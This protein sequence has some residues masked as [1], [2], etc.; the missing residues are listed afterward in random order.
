MARIALHSRNT[1]QKKCLLSLKG[2]VFEKC[3]LR[4]I[5]RILVVL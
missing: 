4:V 5:A 1:Q 3:V 2:I